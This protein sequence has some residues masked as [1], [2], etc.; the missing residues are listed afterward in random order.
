M[1]DGDDVLRAGKDALSAPDTGSKKAA[2]PQGL[3]FVFATMP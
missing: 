2:E 3:L 1:S